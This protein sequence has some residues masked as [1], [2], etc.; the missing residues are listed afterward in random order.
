MFVALGRLA[1]TA[2][3]QSNGRAD[4]GGRC[5]RWVIQR[6]N[7]RLQRLRRMIARP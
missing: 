7:K 6:A 2:I 3:E 4:L 5:G 1:P